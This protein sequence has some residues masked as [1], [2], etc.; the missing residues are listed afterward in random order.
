MEDRRYTMELEFIKNAKINDDNRYHYVITD[1]VT[2]NKI[3]NFNTLSEAFLACCNL[4]YDDNLYLKLITE[5]IEDDSDNIVFSTHFNMV[6]INY[7][8][9]INSKHENRIKYKTL[10]N[11]RHENR[12]T[13]TNYQRS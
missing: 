10:I 7:K 12:T 13:S 9:L 4:N 3:E 11:T 5:Y 8:T 2:D 1:H 6:V